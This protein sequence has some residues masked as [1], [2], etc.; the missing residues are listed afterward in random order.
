MLDVHAR[1][2][3]K[4]WHDFIV[5]CEHLF[6]RN[7]YSDTDLEKMKIDDIEKYHE[8]FERVVELFPVVESA[9]EDENTSPELEGFMLEELDN[10]Y[11]TVD[12]LKETIDK[13]VL[14]KKRFVKTDFADKIISFTYSCLIKFV[15]TDKVKGMPM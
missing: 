3:H 15:E 9:L 12:G 6:L 8:F 1:A 13:V 10:L 4:R 7:I 5:E 2:E 11:S 14:Q